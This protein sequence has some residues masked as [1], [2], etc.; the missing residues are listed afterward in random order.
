MGVCAKIK[1]I[2]ENSLSCFFLLMIKKHSKE[3]F[4]HLKGL[5][6]IIQNSSLH[7]IAIM[8]IYGIQKLNFLDWVLRKD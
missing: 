6:T 4:C 5:M 2:K 3:R 1:I 8:T 7:F